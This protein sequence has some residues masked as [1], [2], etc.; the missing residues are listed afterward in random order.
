MPIV[1]MWNPNGRSWVAGPCT[2]RGILKSTNGITGV[3]VTS[4]VAIDRPRVRFAGNALSFSP[5]FVD[6]L[7]SEVYCV[8]CVDRP[9]LR[10]IWSR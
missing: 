1:V 3:V 4:I 7:L 2:N 10:K 8:R 9:Y 6:S 5:L